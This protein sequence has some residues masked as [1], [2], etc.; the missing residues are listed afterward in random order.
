[1]TSKLK[2]VG[3]I[4]TAVEPFFQHARCGYTDG[5]ISIE[6]Y[7]FVFCMNHLHRLI[8]FLARQP[9][10]NEETFAEPLSPSTLSWHMLVVVM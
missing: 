2:V 9:Q 3:S 7:L 5:N 8:Q 1:L 6:K 10:I 4:P